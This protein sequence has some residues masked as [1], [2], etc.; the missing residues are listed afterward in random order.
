MMS[1]T[2]PL[3]AALA[4]AM[5]GLTGCA[6][7]G[8]NIR[9]TDKLVDQSIANVN[10]ASSAMQHAKSARRDMA[11]V[12]TDQQYVST[13][14][15]PVTR[16]SELPAKCNITFS[17]SN[18]LTL[19]ETG[20]LISKLC[21]LQVR[22]TPDAISGGSSA[23]EPS[24][25][26][27]PP[28]PQGA[29]L[30]PGVSA[31]Q[32]TGSPSG[33]GWVPGT[34]NDVGSQL[35]DIRYTGDLPGFLDA[36]TARFGLSW[37]V[38]HGAIVIF[39]IETRV[40]RIYNLPT[41]LD[42]SS[43]F[44][45]GTKTDSGVSGGGGSSGGGGGS[46][47]GSSGGVGGNAGSMQTTSVG[48]KTNPATDLIASIKAMTTPG[49][50]KSFYSSSNST[51]IVTDTPEVLD[52]VQSY[53]ESLNATY[54]KQVLINVQLLSVT[55]S[56]S[57]SYG[58]NWNAVYKDLNKNF[59]FSLSNTYTASTGA[60]SGAINILSGNSQWSGSQALINALS[61]QGKVRVLVEPS[62]VARNLKPAP[63]QIAHQ[64]G[65]IA[66]S[67][68]TITGS[69]SGFSQSS[70]TPGT[71]TTGFNMWAMPMVYPDNKTI[72]L[73]LS[74]NLSDLV[75]I[76]RKESGNSAIEVPEID[77]KMF[78]PDVQLRSGDTAVIASFKQSSLDNERSGTGS[79]HN[80]LLGGGVTGTNKTVYIVI[81]VTPVVLANK[82]PPS[83]VSLD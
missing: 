63:I 83:T 62:V 69:S 24:S 71:V 45:S 7:V 14:P 68:N 53:V 58:L 75:N 28:A 70:I 50:G 38:D 57:D 9:S 72:E 77:N 34:Q 74:I 30:P 11:A 12:I 19:L 21:G 42:M 15:I 4:L 3:A 6:S 67:S 64:T 2:A 35:V 1:R 36:L 26:N 61:T 59:G 54:S 43:V 37:R 48:L 5:L 80:W 13:T 29:S 8:A 33:G 78:S 31:P 73:S 39:H 44:T 46:S 22:I 79:A 76:L 17:P 16:A 51:L 52:R 27:L 81:V 49:Q 60:V 47:G 41:T 56:S 82:I 20:Q 10:T 65:F 66:Q 55:I 18:G 25:T 40:F 23:T 32:A